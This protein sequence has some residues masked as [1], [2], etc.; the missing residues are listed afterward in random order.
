MTAPGCWPPD[1]GSGQH[2]AGR[3]AGPQAPRRPAGHLPGPAPQPAQPQGPGRPEHGA[4]T[5]YRRQPE[6]GPIQ[7]APSGSGRGRRRP[8]RSCRS[9][10]PRPALGRPHPRMPGSS[11]MP[12][13]RAWLA[14]PFATAGRGADSQ[15]VDAVARF[16]SAPH[17]SA[18][19]LRRIW[20]RRVKSWTCHHQWRRPP[21]RR[22]PSPF[23]APLSPPR[24]EH[25]PAAA[26]QHADRHFG[27]AGSR[28]L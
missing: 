5:R 16:S 17:L 21:T 22:S 3:P 6:T 24:P 4:M 8:A 18:R 7:Q 26:G 19:Q 9:V 13:M 1:Q 11:P 23:S 12:W 25:R 20:S 10:P 28:L 14:R 15:G 2:P 27:S